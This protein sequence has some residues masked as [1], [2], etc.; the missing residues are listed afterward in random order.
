MGATATVSK[1]K[2]GNKDVALK[3]FIF[4]ELSLDIVNE[5][6]RESLLIADI[7]HSN[8]VEF[9]GACLR[10]PELC[11][12]YEYCSCGDLTHL[13]LA[14][15]FNAHF[16]HSTRSQNNKQYLIS[17]PPTTFKN[18]LYMLIG[19][20]RGMTKL[21]DELIIHRDLKTSNILVNYSYS[22]QKYIAKVCDFGSA[23][24]LLN[25]KQAKSLDKLIKNK[26]Y[27]PPNIGRNDSESQTSPK[28]LSIKTPDS[29]EIKKRHLSATNIINKIRSS[30]D[31]TNSSMLF[32]VNDNSLINPNESNPLPYGKSKGFDVDPLAMTTQVGTLAFMAP[33]IIAHINIGGMGGGWVN[34]NNDND[35]LNDKKTN[36]NSDN[37]TT[38]EYKDEYELKIPTQIPSK[39]PNKNIIVKDRNVETWKDTQ[40]MP[41]LNGNGNVTDNKIPSNDEIELS[42]GKFG[43]NINIKSDEDEKTSLIGKAPI[44]VKFKKKTKIG[45]KSKNTGKK[46]RYKQRSETNWTKKISQSI[47]SGNFGSS[48]NSNNFNKFKPGT[49]VDSQSH[50]TIQF[51]VNPSDTSLY[52][53][54]IDV[55][56]FGVIMYEVGSLIRIYEGM[57]MNAIRDMV[58][59][60][61][62]IKYSKFEDV[63]GAIKKKKST[64]IDENDNNNSNNN[65]NVPM[66]FDGVPENVYYLYHKLIN[67][68]WAQKSNQRPKF[69]VI[70]EKLSHILKVYEEEM[71]NIQI[72][73]NESVISNGFYND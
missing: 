15:Y 43:N 34:N 4:D 35:K 22:K 16:H 46:I 27:T 32:G 59:T 29:N 60:G 65:D 1:A 40:S 17:N 45:Y 44:D 8:I 3:I 11:L 28:Y 13:L 69:W 58:V 56:S 24:K 6:F 39:V 10:P 37:D 20:A 7:K 18:R 54:S 2:Y 70:E 5:F 67:E 48:I 30:M 66:G 49:V 53:Q 47:K 72:K 31:N 50:E 57:D 36:N 23:R 25:T 26:S 12:V 64:I 71:K 73:I 42:M 51:E 41:V 52:N 68:C 14:R 61:K 55:Y 9:K 21:H 33:E 19:I 62:R 38:L 63:N